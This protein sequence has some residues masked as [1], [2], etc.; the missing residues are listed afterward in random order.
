MARVHRYTMS[1]QSGNE[2]VWVHRYTMSKQSA[3]EFVRVHRYTMG[4]QS[5]S[6]FAR[7]YR[8]TMSKQS[9]NECVAWEEGCGE[10]VRVRS[11]CMNSDGVV[12]RRPHLALDAVADAVRAGTLAQVVRAVPLHERAQLPRDRASR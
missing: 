3:S 6:Q 12:W 8:Y 11:R 10:R 7:S 2:C 5:V 4:K 1:N 9:G